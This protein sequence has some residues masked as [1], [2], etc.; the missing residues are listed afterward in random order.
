MQTTPLS[1]E[2]PEGRLSGGLCTPEDPRGTVLLLHGIPSINPPDPDDTGYPGL[3]ES[4]A[5][6]GW[7]GAWVDLRAVRSSP[8]HFSIEG[9]VRD[10]DAVAAALRDRITGPLVVVGSSAGGSVATVAVARGLVVEGLVLWAA[11][12]VWVSFAGSPQEAVLRITEQAGMVLAPEVLEDPTG[13]A[14][15]F[16]SVCTADAAQEVSVPMLVVHGDADDVVPVGHARQIAEAAPDAR[17]EILDGAG[18]QLR[19]DPRCLKLLFGWLG[20]HFG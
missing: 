10:V 3:A 18:H 12:A 9:W 8:G 14:A 7:T 11:P 15:E 6:H 17:V 16:D 4:V 19:R 20:E 5:S 13:W 2:T 1:I